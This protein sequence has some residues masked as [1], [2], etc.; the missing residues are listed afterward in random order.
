[1]TPFLIHHLVDL[2]WLLSLFFGPFVDVDYGRTNLC[3]QSG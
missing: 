3:L 1:M 2:S